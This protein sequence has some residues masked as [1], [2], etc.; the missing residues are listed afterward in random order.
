MATGPWIIRFIDTVLDL[1]LAKGQPSLKEVLIRHR[2]HIVFAL[3][4][5]V[6]IVAHQG[7]LFL[8]SGTDIQPSTTTFSKQILPVV[9][10]FRMLSLYA[11]GVHRRLWRYTDGY[12]FVRLF[13]AT[14]VSSAAIWVIVT[15]FLGNTHPS[16]VYLTDGV[17]CFLLLS[18]LRMV[19]RT[20]RVLTRLPGG[21]AKRTLIIGAGDAG[22]MIAREMQQNVGYH[23]K[24]VA[25]L[26]DRLGNQGIRIHGIPVAGTIEQMDAVAKRYHADEILI[27]IPSATPKQQVRILRACRPLNLPIKTMPSLLELLHGK[28]AITAIH[29]LTVE[30]LTGRAAMEINDAKVQEHIAGK[31]ILVTGAGGSIGSELCLQI[32]A[33]GPTKLILYEQNESNLHHCHVS[34]SEQYPGVRVEVILG[35]ILD[36]SFL[37]S[38][39]ATHKPHM[40]FHAAA[41]KHVPMMERNILKAVQNNILGTYQVITAAIAHHAQEFVLISTDKAVLPSSVMGAT[42]RVAEMLVGY[43]NQKSSTTLVSVRF[44]NV[45]ESNGSVVPHFRKQILRGGPVT[46]TDM[47]ITRYFITV[48]EAVSLVLHASILG[49]GGEVFVL[50][51][52]DPVKIIDLAHNMIRLAGL[53]PGKDIAIQT[54]GL[55]PGEKLHE[56]I[57]EEGETVLPTRHPKIHLA[58][59]G[60]VSEAII[61]DIKRLSVLDDRA[62]PEE[63]KRLLMTVVPTYRSVDG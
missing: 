14:V 6:I 16:E 56:A 49:Q 7:A 59:N 5:I 9:L 39:F 15:F 62:T 28:R 57:F 44:G 3:N 25:F 61:A 55:R 13:F 29:E 43:F 31:C 30:D 33:F 19:K 26:D 51:M 12:D 41:Y 17:L 54:I 20:Y 38:T 58:R 37:R 32:A 50:D 4:V 47:E 35:D 18:G 52:G 46:I 11:F 8:S 53:T 24:P 42:K 21:T 45:L 2:G 22:E 34:L 48:Q 63:I 27:A 1:P 23:H 60:T 36:E 10:L 40:V